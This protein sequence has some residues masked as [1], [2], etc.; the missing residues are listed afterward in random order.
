MK[1]AFL[2]ASVSAI[3]VV[4][5]SPDSGADPEHTYSIHVNTAHQ[6][7]KDA[8]ARHQANFDRVLE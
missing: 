3:T 1:F 7:I 8:S 4:K 2:L 5:N 6:A